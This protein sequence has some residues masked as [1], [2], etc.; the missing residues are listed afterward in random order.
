MYLSR[1]KLNPRSRELRRIL[2][3]CHRLHQ[4]VMGAFPDHPEGRHGLGVLFRLEARAGQPQLLVQSREE[5]DW[6]HLDE[7][8]LAVDW[9][10][11]ETNP[12]TRAITSA[13][14]GIQTGQTLRFR[15]DAN[16]TRRLRRDD[17]SG[18]AGQRVGLH[19][20]ASCLDWLARR[21]VAAGFELAR[22]P[23]E[24]EVPA[25]QVQPLGDR[26]GWKQGGGKK[27]RLTHHAV[28][29]DGRLRVTDASLLREAITQGIGPAKAYGFG[30]LSLAR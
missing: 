26:I 12:Q 2:S 13:L 19:T 1:L 27:R 22:V 18:R 15:L 14:E 30:L 21:G 17:E 11:G 9:L 4:A 25:V 28:R 23:S 5:P 8:W 24:P 7:G 3:D 10:P 6:G 20:D 29:F 16:P